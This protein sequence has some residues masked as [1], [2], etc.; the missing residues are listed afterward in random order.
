[1]PDE[2]I[3]FDLDGVLTDSRAAIAGSVNHALRKNGF[4]ERPEPRLHRFIGPP[5]AMAFAELT[6]QPVDSA[7]VAACMS[8]YRERYAEVLAVETKAVPGMAEL[9][10]DLSPR[11]PLGVATSKPLLFTEPILEALGLRGLFDAVAGPA[12]SAFAEDKSVTVAAALDL[13]HCGSGVMVGDRSFD[14]VAAHANGLTAIGVTW[15]IGTA[16]ELA[17]AGADVI[18][19]TPGDLA[20]MLTK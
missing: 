9:L 15:G 18:V 13:L 20:A 10:A 2:A 7:T 17:A 8:S 16:D 3:L 5:L 6:R 12:V 1:M 4:S 11:R 19:D 14:V